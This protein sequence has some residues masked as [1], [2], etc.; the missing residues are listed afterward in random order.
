M[1]VFI[2]VPVL[3]VISAK[4]ITV[5]DCLRKFKPK[6]NSCF[7]CSVIMT[8]IFQLLLS[9]ANWRSVLFTINTEDLQIGIDGS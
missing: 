9:E 7:K 4:L 5:F 1:A 8:G 6:T 2:S 3:T